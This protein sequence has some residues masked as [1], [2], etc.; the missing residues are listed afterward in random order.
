MNYKVILTTNSY[1]YFSTSIEIYHVLAYAALGIL[2][3]YH[4]EILI[5]FIKI[6]LEIVSN[7]SFIWTEKICVQKFGILGTTLIGDTNL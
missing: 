2:Y 4:S 6:T 1:L 7:A 3:N 5:A